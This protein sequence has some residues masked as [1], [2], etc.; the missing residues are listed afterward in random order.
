MLWPKGTC[1]G[2]DGARVRD[3]W[4]E[5]GRKGRMYWDGWRDGEM[6]GGTEGG[7]EVS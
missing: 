7:I 1:T 5:G 3:V 6:V 2:M 4:R